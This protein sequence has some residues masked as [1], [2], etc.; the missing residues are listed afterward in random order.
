MSE[1]N[2]SQD[3]AE[4][5]AP[6]RTVGDLYRARAKT[7]SLRLSGG[8][9]GLE[10][11]IT[12]P[13]VQRLGLALAG[14]VDYLHPGRVQVLGR[15]EARLLRGLDPDQR[16]EALE[17]PLSRRLS[18]L[19]LTFG[20]E[21]PPE[22]VEVARRYATPILLTPVATPRAIDEIT[23]YLD[24]GLSP[25]I[26]IHGVLVDVFG[27]GVLIVGESG[28]GKSECALELVMRGH[29][30]VADD[31]VVV[32]RFGADRLM[33]SGPDGMRF[34]MEVRG[35]GIINI[36]DLFGISAVEAQK[37]VELAVE[38]VHWRN[39]DDLE[40]IDVE[41]KRFEIL[42]T[43][44]PRITLPVGSGR[45]AASLVEVAVRLQLLRKQGY[46]PSEGFFQALEDR[47]E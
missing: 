30:L 42:D 17:L 40:R 27:L 5:E 35:L 18:C 23:E 38:L 20:E 19:V 14:Y 11:R 1:Q 8:V 46:R 15:T 28:V 34:F 24:E 29:R 12:V 33:G 26:D 22:M 6:Y 4:V 21:P 37:Q 44:I 3:G 36:R 7:L 16:R 9:N 43:W 32:R 10:N 31:L 47:L 13:R 25:R 45:N 2:K 41:E 39:W